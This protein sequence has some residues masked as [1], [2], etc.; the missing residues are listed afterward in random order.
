MRGDPAALPRPGGS[1]SPRAKLT[2]WCAGHIAGDL[3]REKLIRLR[4]AFAGFAA[5]LFAVVAIL[6]RTQTIDTAGVSSLNFPPERDK[7]V[8]LPRFPRRAD[9][10][11]VVTYETR[12]KHSTWH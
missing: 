3:R 4:L 7:T 9:T 5:S 6:Y 11:R 12:C 8:R 10:L 1:G 2:A